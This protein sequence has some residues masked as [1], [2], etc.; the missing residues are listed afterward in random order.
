MPRPD[1]AV[2]LRGCPFLGEHLMRI[3]VA[4]GARRDD[5][6]AEQCHSRDGRATSSDASGQIGAP[7]R[8]DDED[9]LELCEFVDDVQHD[10]EHPVA[11]GD[12]RISG[13]R[14]ESRQV[15]VDATITRPPLEHVVDADEQVAVIELE[16]MEEQ[17]GPS[18]SPFDDVERPPTE[19]LQR[20]RSVSDPP[21]P[22]RPCAPPG[23]GSRRRRGPAG[24]SA[25]AIASRRPRWSPRSRAPARGVPVRTTARR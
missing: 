22:S 18:G 24:R 19:P 1:L 20:H 6:R 15:D 7:R 17:H 12:G 3:E 21:R 23:S 25:R 14:S 4:L 13:R 5:H 11:S 2:L 16:A 8:A 9:R 10:V